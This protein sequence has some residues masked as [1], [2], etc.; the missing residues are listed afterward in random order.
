[1]Y[2]RLK[3]AKPYIAAI[4]IFGKKAKNISKVYHTGIRNWVSDDAYNYSLVID[5]CRII[6]G[7][8]RKQYA[9]SN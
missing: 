3:K 8:E 9:S 5:R 6:I 7:F 1:M 4:E 2:K